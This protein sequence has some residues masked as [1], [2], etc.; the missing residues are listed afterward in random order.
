M[1]TWSPISCDVRGYIL[2]RRGQ[3]GAAM[4]LIE[5]GLGLARQLGETHLTARLL[6]ARAF[7]LDLEDDRAGAARDAAESLQLYRQVGDRRQ[8]GTMLGNLGYVELSIGDIDVACGHLL[9]S[10]DIARELN[11][12]YG[13]VYE[14]FNLGLADYLSRLA[15]M[16]PRISSRNRSTWPGA[17][18]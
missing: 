16:R 17:C 6:A 18:R 14:T 4:P 7:A 9:E 10:L 8:V 13:V 3:P 1:T 12:H 15:G 2:L 5:R 11:D